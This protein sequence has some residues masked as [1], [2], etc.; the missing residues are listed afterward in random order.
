MREREDDVQR[1]RPEEDLENRTES[2]SG[3]LAKSVGG[4]NARPKVTE[5]FQYLR[6]LRRG[7]G[8]PST[9]VCSLRVE[10]YKNRVEHKT[11]RRMVSLMR[12]V[13]YIDDEVHRARVRESDI[14]RESRSP[15]SQNEFNCDNDFWES[16]G[17][18]Q[19]VHITWRI[20]LYR[21][22]YILRA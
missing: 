15:G 19:T 10:N 22:K 4:L 2:P 21:K 20:Q 7:S 16:R 5:R 17:R 3:D 12:H 9:Y 11:S 6:K 8:I 14:N 1:L 13:K 18:N